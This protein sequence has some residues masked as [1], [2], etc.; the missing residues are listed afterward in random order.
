MK[1]FIVPF[2]CLFIIVLVAINH[3][4]LVDFATKVFTNKQHL[5]ILAGNEYTKSNDYLYVQRSNDYTPLGY[6]DVLNIYYSIINNHW[7]TFTFYCPSEY[8][9]CIDDITKLSDSSLTLSNINNFVHP[10]NSFTNIKTT[11]DSNGEIIVKVSYLYTKDQINYINNEVDRIISENY[12]SE[13][14]TK[15]N[16]K[17]IHDYI[18]NNTK[19]DVDYEKNKPL[20][21]YNAYGALKEHLATCNGY[22]DLM[23]IILSKLN[24][25]NYKIAYNPG[26]NKETEGHVWNAAYIDGSWLHIDLTWDDPVGDGRDYLYHKYF[27]VNTEEMKE[28]DTGNIQ[29]IEHDFDKKVYQEF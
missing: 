1:K 13:L 28:A 3:T 23:A 11:I 15:E 7:D 10:Y 21:T 8:S 12:N 29:V 5:N 26:E 20:Q 27:L 22:S 17:N 6:Q 9:S 18:I 19:Y 14:N 16:L 24:I 2:L 4:K 25:N